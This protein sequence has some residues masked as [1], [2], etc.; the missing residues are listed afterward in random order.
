MEINILLTKWHEIYRLDAFIDRVVNKLNS[1]SASI[2]VCCPRIDSPNNV[3]KPMTKYRI[4]VKSKISRGLDLLDRQIIEEARNVWET[5]QVDSNKSAADWW[6]IYNGITSV[7]S[8]HLIDAGILPR[9][10]PTLILPKLMSNE[11]DN[12]LK[13]IIGAWAVSIAN[14]QRFN[15]ISEYWRN[16]QLEPMLEKEIDNQPYA[17][18]K[19]NEYPEW[20]LFEIEQSL[21]IRRIQIEIAKR[22]IVEDSPSDPNIKHFTMQLNMGEGK[23]AVIVPILAAILSNG[24]Q[25]CQITV[26]KSLFATN[27]KSLRQYMGGMLGRKV[28]L[29]PCRRDLEISRYVNQIH[30]MYQECMQNKGN[31]MR[32]Q[33][34]MTQKAQARSSNTF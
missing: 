20:L 31:V 6:T 32:P 9:S 2:S 23:T 18:W 19:P 8:Q 29:F 15:R 3:P 10:V 14:E 5:G 34:S 22:M 4:D 27:L 33:Y 30:K 28:Y 21:T 1:L 13:M 25:I 7:E 16:S 24:Q 17:N 26:L 12:R 11:T